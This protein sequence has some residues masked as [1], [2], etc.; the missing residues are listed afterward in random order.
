[1]CLDIKEPLIESVKRDSAK[2]EADIVEVKDDNEIAP[3]SPYA[4][5]NDNENALKKLVKSQDD[6]VQINIKEEEDDYDDGE[7]EEVEEVGV[8]LETPAEPISVE[9]II[10]D[11]DDE[12]GIIILHLLRPI[13]P[14][15]MHA[16][17]L[18]TVMV[19]TNFLNYVFRN[20]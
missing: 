10:D 1:M 15:C 13:S 14:S 16:H 2:K 3:P 11:D 19:F 5:N 17:A 8:G 18:H 20:F 9:M 4:N 12:E 6:L 7:Q